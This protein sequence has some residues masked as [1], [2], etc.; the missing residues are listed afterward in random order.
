[1]YMYKP[2]LINSF[3]ELPQQLK[4]NHML[5]H[6]K[7][8]SNVCPLEMRISPLASNNLLTHINGYCQS[9]CVLFVVF[10]SLAPCNSHRLS[11]NGAV[12]MSAGTP[13]SGLSNDVMYGCNKPSTALKFFDLSR[14]LFMLH[15]ICSCQSVQL[16]IV[17]L[18]M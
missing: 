2:S 5:F 14:Q 9:V 17:S 4:D 12:L 3:V 16:K 8:L 15:Q 7:L 18:P 13:P 11:A 6:C 10:P 1:M